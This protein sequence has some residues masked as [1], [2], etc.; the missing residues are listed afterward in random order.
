MKKPFFAEM[1]KYDIHNT[2]DIVRNIK[3]STASTMELERTLADSL[4]ETF[5][6]LFL[7]HQKLP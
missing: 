7:F 5:L 6:G 1:I 2:V 3:S 4:G